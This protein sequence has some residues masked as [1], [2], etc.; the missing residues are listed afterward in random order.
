METPDDIKQQL[1]DAFPEHILNCEVDLI[2]GYTNPG[3]G[4]RGQ[5]Q[6]I[7]DDEDVQDM[8]N[9]YEGKNEALLWFY[10]PSGSSH[11]GSRRARSHSPN[12]GE[13]HRRRNR[14]I[15]R[16][17]WKRRT[18]VDKLKEKHLGKY[19]EEKL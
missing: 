2:I 7:I 10:I 5:L 11:D 6:W 4:A 13:K 1:R 9:E 15:L 3:H 18:V 19:P 14:A 12:P 17:S 8:Y 16:A